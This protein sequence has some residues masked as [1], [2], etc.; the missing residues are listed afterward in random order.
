MFSRQ[1]P[2]KVRHVALFLRHGHGDEEM[3]QL[4]AV[5]L[6]YDFTPDL[7]AAIGGA[8]P[9]I[10]ATL[11]AANEGV[12]LT[13]AGLVLDV[14]EVAITMKSA[15]KETMKVERTSKLKAKARK[16]NAEDTGPTLEATAI[17]RLDDDE[18]LMFLKNQLGELVKVRLDRRQLDIP[19]TKLPEGEA[20]EEPEG[21]AEAN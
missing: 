20:A 13:R 7:A 16:A 18:S 3:Q 14:K 19:E 2:A 17:F 15:D 12:S 4:C 5:L 1:F 10:Q 21:E 8:A 9:Q 11:A 6:Q